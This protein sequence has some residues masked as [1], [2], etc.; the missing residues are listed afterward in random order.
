MDLVAVEDRHLRHH[1]AADLAADLAAAEAVDTVTK[2]KNVSLKADMSQQLN[3]RYYETGD[4]IRVKT[5][6]V[7]A[8][9]AA[10]NTWIV[11]AATTY[12]VEE[13]EKDQFTELQ[14]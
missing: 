8:T 9:D 12:K 3:N 7:S 13:I 11:N 10:A 1:L 4:T 5:L 6:G 14:I 2:Y